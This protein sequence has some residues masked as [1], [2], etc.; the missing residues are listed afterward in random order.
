M[1]KYK[2][3]LGA[4]SA[5][6]LFSSF[7]LANAETKILNYTDPVYKIEVKYPK[8]WTRKDGLKEYPGLIAVFLSARESAGDIFQ[9]NVNLIVQD[10]S[11][12]PMTLSNY[13]LLSTNQVNKLI[14][15]SKILES[16]DFVWNGL[17]AHFMVYQ[18]KQ[19]QM[20]LKF[21]QAVTIKNSKAY[22]ITYTAEIDKYDKFLSEA[23][24]IIDSL[25]I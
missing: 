16:Q 10:L 8:T 11:T 9:E 14:S 3:W 21:Y 24:I 20:L 1:K 23:K 6:T 2:T 7:G 12:N 18:G 4:L 13:V 22:L 19:A 17:P 5:L 25:K 15:E